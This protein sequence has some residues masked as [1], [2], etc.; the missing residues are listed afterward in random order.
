MFVNECPFGKATQ[1][2]TLKHATPVATQARRFAWSAQCRLWV[3]ALKR[4]AGETSSARSARL[5][6]RSHN[7]VADTGMCDIGAD[8]SHDP[9]D[10]VAQHRRYGRDVVSGE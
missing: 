7:V 9:R 10:L 5:R 3:L 6:K 2:E 4:P 8:N 1:P